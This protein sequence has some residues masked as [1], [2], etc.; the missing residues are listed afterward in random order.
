MF[1]ATVFQQRMRRIGTRIIRNIVQ[2]C[3]QHLVIFII[4]QGI[5]QYHRALTCRVAMWIG[6][7]A[8]MGLRLQAEHLI[9]VMRLV[10]QNSGIWMGCLQLRRL[11]SIKLRLTMY[12]KMEAKQ[13][14]L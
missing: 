1:P 14:I 12:M 9:T 3:R 4:I 11:K 5:S 7:Q 13:Q 10:P 6:Q 2:Q 8:D